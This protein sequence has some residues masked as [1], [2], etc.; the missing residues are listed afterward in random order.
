MSKGIALE[1]AT[2]T[3]ELTAAPIVELTD[4]EIAEIYGA[5]AHNCNSLSICE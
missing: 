5:G 2:L 1:L 4:A 3:E